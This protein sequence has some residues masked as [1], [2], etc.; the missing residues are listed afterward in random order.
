MYEDMD[1]CLRPDTKYMYHLFIIR[2]DLLHYIPMFILKP[3]VKVIRSLDPM[4][5]YHIV[6]SY[7][8]LLEDI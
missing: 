3:V 6:L 7:D 5:I 2:V 1:T 8:T 4:L